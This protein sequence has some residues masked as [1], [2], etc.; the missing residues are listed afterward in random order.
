MSDTDTLTRNFES[1]AVVAPTLSPPGDAADHGPSALKDGLTPVC[2]GGRVSFIAP[3][4]LPSWEV[5]IALFK[6]AEYEGERAYASGLLEK[7]RPF[8][9]AECADDD[10]IACDKLHLTAWTRKGRRRLT[11]FGLSIAND[12]ATAVARAHDWHVF[13]RQL[14]PRSGAPFSICACGKFLKRVRKGTM[15]ESALGKAEQEHLQ[16][17]GAK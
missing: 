3:S 16:F 15:P 9:V 8:G 13:R 4:A 11:R 2:E 5:M 12:C 7:L 6:I 1:A 17:V 14:R 10:F